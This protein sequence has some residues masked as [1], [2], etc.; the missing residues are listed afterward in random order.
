MRKEAIA[1]KSDSK[2]EYGVFGPFKAPREKNELLHRSPEAINQFWQQVDQSEEGLSKACGCYI[3][4]VRKKVWYVGLAKKQA[5]DKE[6][7]A[8]GKRNHFNDAIKDGGGNA[9]LY[10]IARK[11][12]QGKFTAASRRHGDIEN[13]EKML[14]KFA[15]ER[16]EDLLNKKHTNFYLDT[17]V[18]GILN[19]PPG[20]GGALSVQKLKK[21]LGIKSA[22]G[23][24]KTA[25]HPVSLKEL[26]DAGVLK[27]GKITADYK[28]GTLAELLPNG[29]VKYHGEIYKSGGLKSQSQSRL[30]K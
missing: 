13:L 23:L 29:D 28:E 4:S 16:N 17:V 14:I 1:M 10:L 15:L 2:I 9:H 30:G 3:I 11:T 8:V 21:V 27:P 26:I 7:F 25:K 20:K 19:S 24:T 6:C 12:P 22:N 18:P 5:F